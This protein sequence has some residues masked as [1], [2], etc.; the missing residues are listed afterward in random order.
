MFTHAYF[1][2]IFET[3]SVVTGPMRFKSMIGDKFLDTRVVDENR[4]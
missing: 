3:G 2:D 1:V 4:I